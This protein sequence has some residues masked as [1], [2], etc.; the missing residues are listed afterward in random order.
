MVLSEYFIKVISNLS[1]KLAQE[2]PHKIFRHQRQSSKTTKKLEL[3]FASL[4][5]SNEA[6]NIKCCFK[7]LYNFWNYRFDSIEKSSFK[8]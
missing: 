3:S 7:L 8:K 1:Y 2:T 6:G 4:G 5:K